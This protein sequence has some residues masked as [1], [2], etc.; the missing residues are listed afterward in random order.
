MGRRKDAGRL[1]RL[2]LRGRMPVTPAEQAGGTPA[3]ARPATANK[4]A[5][6]HLAFSPK[7]KMKRLRWQV[8]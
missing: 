5:S 7:T 2:R 8:F 6:I 4:K 3:G 1:T